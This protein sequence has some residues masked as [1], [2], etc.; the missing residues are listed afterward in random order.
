MVHYL[1]S[2]SHRP[3][4]ART[5]SL[6]RLMSYIVTKSSGVWAVNCG[7]GGR[8]RYIQDRKKQLL[9][10]SLILHL[11][12]REGPDNRSRDGSHWSDGRYI[13]MAMRQG[14]NK[15]DLLVGRL[16]LLIYIHIFCLLAKSA[17][18]DR[19]LLSQWGC[20]PNC[21]SLTPHQILS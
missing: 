18:D 12:R 6:K 19:H 1:P 2:D 11:I 8:T 13:K 16:N 21:V 15:S 7:S 3:L 20:H 14:T 10:L 17:R 9:S 5:S 4:L